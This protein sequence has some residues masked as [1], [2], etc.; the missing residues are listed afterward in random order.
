ML[1]ETLYNNLFELIGVPFIEIKVA[2][3]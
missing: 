2:G 1:K 3:K